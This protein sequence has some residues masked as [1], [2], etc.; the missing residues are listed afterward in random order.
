MANAFDKQKP[1]RSGGELPSDGLGFIRTTTY[2]SENRFLQAAK[3]ESMQEKCNYLIQVSSYE[4]TI[5]KKRQKLS[6]ATFK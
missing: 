5:C 2:E 1:H 6:S 3:I 4:T